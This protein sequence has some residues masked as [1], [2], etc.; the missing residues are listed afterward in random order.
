MGPVLNDPERVDDVLV[1]ARKRPADTQRLR[2]FMHDNGD[3]VNACMFPETDIDIAISIAMR[4]SHD[5]ILQK[6]LFA[7][8]P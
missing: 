8:L 1:A 3:L 2:K 6:T 5:N 7:A 4:F